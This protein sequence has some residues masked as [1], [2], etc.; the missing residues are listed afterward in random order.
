MKLRIG[1]RK[2]KLALIQTEMVRQAILEHFPEVEVEIVEMSTKGDEILDKSLT[3]FGGKGVFTQELEDA[4]L[5]EDIDLAVHSA[6]DMPMEFPEGLYIGAVLDRADPRD[7]VV[8]TTGV[9]AADLAPGSVMGTSSLRREL[10]IREINPLLRIAMLRGN[11]QTRL[12]KL[13]EGQYD[14]ILLAAAGLS[15]LE[16]DSEQDLYFEYLEPETFLPAAGQGILA[17]EAKEGRFPEVLKAIHSSE[18]ALALRAERSFLQVLGGSCNAPAAA[19]CVRSGEQEL[20]MSVRY[21]PEGSGA[22][23]CAK[24]SIRLDEQ[25]DKRDSEQ[26]TEQMPEQKDNRQAE[27]QLA[28]QPEQKDRG[29]NEQGNEQQGERLSGQQGIVASVAF[30]PKPDAAGARALDAAARLGADLARKMLCGKVWL[31]G[32]GPGDMGLLTQKALSCVREADVVIY[33]NLASGSILNEAR[34]DAELIYAGKRSSHHHLKQWETNQLLVDRALKG[35]KVARVKG[36]DPFIFGRGGEEAQELMKAGISFEIVPGVSSSYSAPAY[37]GIPVTHRDYASSFHVITGHE[38][39][40]KDGVVLDYETLAHEEG[41]LVFLMG[42]KNLPSIAAELMAHGKDPQTLAAVVQEGT[43]ARQRVVT[44]PLQDIARRAREEGI[45]TP[46]ITVVGDVV[47][48]QQTLNWRGGLPL[49]GV[50]VL[51]TGT[52]SMCEKQI[53]A[54]SSEGAEPIALSLIYTQKLQEPAFLHAME[55]LEDYSWVVLTSSNGVDFFLQAL[56]ERRVDLRKLGMK[57]AVIGEGTKKSLEQAGIY[58]DFVPSRY[59]SSVLAEEWIPTLT[60]QDRVVLIRAKEAS[61]ELSEA[62]GRAGIP[63]EDAPMYT[64]AVD[65][66]KQDEL[67]RL[68]PESDYVTLAS[69]SAVQAFASMLENPAEPGTKVV[70]IGPVTEKAAKKAGIPVYASAVTYTAEGICDVLK[71]DR[72]KAQQKSL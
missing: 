52:R 50:R 19:L 45:Q 63:Y 25:C 27:R 67:L 34:E 21:A 66:R 64:T 43:T 69:A 6:K 39:A 56:R 11:V 44:A 28:G 33:D 46:A 65:R 20:S 51:L 41:T 40:D 42:L 26:K 2:S 38:S 1:S 71:S 68:L 72:L 7:V 70:C 62:L 31:I 53:E 16:L 54:L 47:S 48:L 61:K 14:A 9:K 12:R 32:A 4:L 23:R 18:A 59:A 49:S 37:A 57:F 8:T 36:G 3:S 5:R 30:G 17:V 24:K 58:A 60:G 29:Q 15:R 55:H 13:R 35:Y 10:Q 22:F